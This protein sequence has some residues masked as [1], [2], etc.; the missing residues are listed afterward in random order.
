MFFGRYYGFFRKEPSIQISLRVKI[1]VRK[2]KTFS[3]GK[4]LGFPENDK[5]HSEN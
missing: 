2:E 1:L 5:A 3:D 4:R